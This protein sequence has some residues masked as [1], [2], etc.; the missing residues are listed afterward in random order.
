MRLPFYLRRKAK[1]YIKNEK[2]WIRI[3]MNNF[4]IL[5]LKLAYIFGRIK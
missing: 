5:C 4:D 2:L 3:K 1:S